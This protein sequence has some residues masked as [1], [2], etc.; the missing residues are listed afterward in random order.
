MLTQM[1][2]HFDNKLVYSSLDNEPKYF[3][4]TNEQTTAYSFCRGLSMKL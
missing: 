4:A 3:G 1:I 2:R